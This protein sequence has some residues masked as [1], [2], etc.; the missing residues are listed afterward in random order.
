M[1]RVV[2]W[3]GR[4]RSPPGAG[5]A[6]QL[7]LPPHL[8]LALRNVKVLG[9]GFA[10]QLYA[11]GLA[12]RTAPPQPHPVYMNVQGGLCRQADLESPWAHHWCG[13]L[14]MVPI[15]HRKV[16][17]DCFAVQALWEAGMLEPGR[18]AL[19]FAVGREF[20]PAF[21]A[22]HGVE[23]VATD[24]DAADARARVW[25]E[26][27]QHAEAADP[28]FHPHLIERAAFDARVRY[29]AV[30]MNRIPDDLKQGGFDFLWSICSLEHCG[31]IEAGLDFVVEAMRC[32][33]P[34]GLAVHTTEFNLDAEGPTVERGSTVLFQQRHIERLGE[35]LAAA[36]HE[37]LPVDFDQGEGVLD[38]YVDLPP[39]AQ[40]DGSSV[41]ADAPHLR[42]SIGDHVATSV[43]FIVRAGGSA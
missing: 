27:G 21:F 2:D 13:R 37:M 20:L 5:S 31:S 29:R 35:R 30:D 32:L 7:D 18:K 9:S 38:A 25:H 14:G 42:L 23:V 11:Q 24:L 17:E 19:G 15:Y 28:L 40:H 1:R 34:G 39:Y 10:R 16:W 41:V 4:R 43:G 6:P 33:K 36:G 26:T 8:H 22:G 12:G 3:M